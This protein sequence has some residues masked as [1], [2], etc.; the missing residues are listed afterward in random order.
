MK[1]GVP[2]TYEAP[3]DGSMIDRSEAVNLARILMDG[4]RETALTGNQLLA[5]AVL[6]MDK[7]L[8]YESDEAENNLLRA[9]G[10][11]L[12]LREEIAALKEIDKANVA[13]ATE[14]STL[15]NLLSELVEAVDGMDDLDEQDGPQFSINSVRLVYA[16]EAARPH[17]EAEMVKQAMSELNVPAAGSE[18]PPATT[19]AELSARLDEISAEPP[20][21]MF[22]V[23]Y[24]GQGKTSEF[25]AI[26]HHEQEGEEILSKR[27][28]VYAP[29]AVP[30]E[31]APSEARGKY[32]QNYMRHNAEAW[33]IVYAGDYGAVAAGYFAREVLHLT[34]ERE[35]LMKA[36]ERSE[37]PA[38][39]AP[40]GSEDV[41][42]EDRFSAVCKLIEDINTDRYGKPLAAA[43]HLCNDLAAELAA[44]D[45]Q[46]SPEGKV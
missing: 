16:M 30:P 23:R 8:R 21:Y 43:L 20:A 39:A 15:R 41:H 14:S 26:D 11:V 6:R 32:G 27:P 40:V 28:L 1:N 34:K 38:S 44:R 37:P 42:G 12:T 17:T 7:A 18:R 33:A 25:A 35:D 29:A 4:H 22:R 10:L 3:Q 19:P 36:N 13:L 31:E 9:D 5:D 24:T 46:H 45:I 2:E